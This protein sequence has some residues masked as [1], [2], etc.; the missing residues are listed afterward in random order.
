[1]EQLGV[2]YEIGSIIVTRAVSFLSPSF[3]VERW[4]SDDVFKLAGDLFLSE[5]ALRTGD[6]AGLVS[7]FLVGVILIFVT[8]W[9]GR[10]WAKALLKSS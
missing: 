9:T 3:Y 2:P 10:L 8:Y 1:M 7:S 5:S 6:V 4:R